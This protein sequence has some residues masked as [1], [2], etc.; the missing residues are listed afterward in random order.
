MCGLAVWFMLQ[1]AAL[2]V[3][4]E[5]LPATGVAAL[6]A[7][8]A[9]ASAFGGAGT[10]WADRPSCWCHLIGLQHQCEIDDSGRL[11]SSKA[12]LLHDAASVLLMDVSGTYSMHDSSRN[13]TTPVWQGGA[14]CQQPFRWDDS[15]M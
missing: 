12:A 14:A 15:S 13:G 5:A 8:A 1:F 6:L 10:S 2:P 4:A 11:S 9:N 7:A 3:A